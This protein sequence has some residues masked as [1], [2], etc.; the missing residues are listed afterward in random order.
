MKTINQLVKDF[1]NGSISAVDLVQAALKRLEEV[2]DKYNIIISYTKDRALLRA[3]EIDQAKAE[4]KSLG[5]LS[6]VPFIAKD[7]FLT[8]GGKTTAASKIL[9]PFEAP[10]QATAIDK[11]EAEGAICIAKANLD[12][13]AHGGSTENSF[14]GPTKNPHDESKV[15]GGSSGGSATAVALDIVPFALGTDTGGSIRQPS[16]FCGVVG[17][18]PTYGMVSRYGVVAMASSTDT[19]GAMANT[20]EDVALV[21]DIMAGQDECDSTTLPD[22]PK[23]LLPAKMERPLK[24]GVIK[25]YMSDAL[26]PDVRARI[27]ARISDL[28]ALGHTVEEVSIPTID[29]ALAIY[30]IVVPAEISSNLARYDGIKYGFS[31]P[32]AQ[33]LDQV[34]ELSRSQGFMHENKRRILIGNYVLSTGHYDAYYNKAQ[35]ARTILINEFDRAFN[36]FD[37]LIGPVAPTTAFK[38]GQHSDNPKQMYLADILTVAPSLAGLPALSLPSGAGEDGM[39]VGMQI[40]GPQK[41]DDLIFSLA[42]QLED[43]DE[44]R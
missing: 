4:G 30:Y 10:Y 33:N 41:S 12:S 16:S 27:D 32:E 13:F 26:A 19:I 18:K 1:S 3:A 7:N 6:G 11:L 31:A 2:Q 9:E 25:E 22:V 5:R 21:M 42:K 15:P 35:C 29:L 28:K 8:F 14:F 38:I 34:Y 23:T 43:Y 24:I 20:V 39:P 40:I 37:F 44:H 17:I 36:Q